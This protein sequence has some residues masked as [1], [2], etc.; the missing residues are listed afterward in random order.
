MKLGGLCCGLLKPLGHLGWCHEGLR[1]HGGDPRQAGLLPA[2]SPVRKVS[3]N[4][5][6]ETAPKFNLI[7]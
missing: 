4:K 1:G 7:H 2:T 3:K 5:A 6:V